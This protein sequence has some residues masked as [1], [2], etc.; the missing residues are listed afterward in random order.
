ML[1]LFTLD[2]NTDGIRF[3]TLTESRWSR[4]GIVPHSQALNSPC[5]VVWQDHLCLLIRGKGDLLFQNTFDGHAFTGWTEFIGG[6]VSR[7][8]PAAVVCQSH[9]H[10]FVHGHDGS[11]WHNIFDGAVTG[12]LEVPGMQYQYLFISKCVWLHLGLDLCL[13]TQE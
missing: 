11:I 1:Y 7:S 9:L 3:S 2:T 13:Y 5:A 8:T 6:G 10:V 4:L 12:W